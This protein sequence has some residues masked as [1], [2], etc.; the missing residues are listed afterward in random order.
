MN[1]VHIN[2]KSNLLP[3]EPE[4]IENPSNHLES[5]KVSIEKDTPDHS[6]PNQSNQSF[7]QQKQSLLES[8]VTNGHHLPEGMMFLTLIV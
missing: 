5:D 6:I 4:Q 1:K 7:A 8:V 3:T 2:D